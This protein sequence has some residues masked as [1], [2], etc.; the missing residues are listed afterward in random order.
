MNKDLFISKKNFCESSFYAYGMSCKET[1]LMVAFHSQDILS[2]LPSLPPSFSFFASI[3]RA[4]RIPCGHSQGLRPVTWKSSQLPQEDMTSTF[5]LCLLLPWGLEALNGYGLCHIQA[6]LQAILSTTNSFH[7]SPNIILSL[8][9]DSHHIT[10]AGLAS[11]L[12]DFLSVLGIFVS[13]TRQSYVGPRHGSRQTPR[14]CVTTWSPPLD[15][16][17]LCLYHRERSKEWSSGSTFWN[18]FIQS[19]TI[20]MF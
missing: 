9:T 3:D 14:T 10:V 8:P 1:W 20:V 16:I 18:D 2:F 4:A 5:H 11:G 6:P 7:F 19:Y 12:S 13:P 15:V 17:S